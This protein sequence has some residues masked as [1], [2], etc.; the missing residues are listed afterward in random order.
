MFS[1]TGREGIHSWVN[2]NGARLLGRGNQETL[3]Q[4]VRRG[5]YCCVEMQRP[6]SLSVAL[7]TEPSENPYQHTH[8]RVL[9]SD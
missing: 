4:D 3:E 9:V 8:T 2:P 6:P 1:N 5:C 7:E